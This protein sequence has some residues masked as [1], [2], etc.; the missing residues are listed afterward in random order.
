ML[1]ST[2]ARMFGRSAAASSLAARTALPSIA[3]VSFARRTFSASAR[4][5]N[6]DAALLDSIKSKLKD[7]MRAKDSTSST[8]L[9]SLLSEYQYAQKQPNATS[10]SSTASLSTVLQK[11]LAKRTEAAAQFRAATPSPRE[12]LAEKEDAEAKIIKAFLPEPMTRDELDGVVR[13]VVESVRASAGGAGVE[14]KKL[15]G[16]V[17]KGVNAI[18]DKSRVTGGEISKAVNDILKS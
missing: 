13:Q 10:G 11:A 6:D 18:V 7:S 12:D 2:S 3:N 8:V 4:T 14:A 9:R 15:V 5:Q 1:A 16:Q 17:I